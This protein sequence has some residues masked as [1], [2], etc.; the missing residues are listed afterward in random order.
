[1]RAAINIAAADGHRAILLVGDAPYYARFGFSRHLTRGLMLPGPVDGERFLGLELVP[2]V[3][4]DAVGMV[5]AT[6]TAEAALSR[7]A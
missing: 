7:A 1:M 6:G 5:D 3:L 2:G 4:A